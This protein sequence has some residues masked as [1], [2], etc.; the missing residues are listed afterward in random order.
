MIGLADANS[1]MSSLGFQQ[2][3][4]P[5]ADLAHRKRMC[6]P[7]TTQLPHTKKQ[8]TDEN[9]AGGAPPDVSE[10]EWRARVDPCQQR[11]GINSMSN[12]PGWF[13]YEHVWRDESMEINSSVQSLYLDHN[14][15]F[16][17]ESATRLA[18]KGDAVVSHQGGIY[19]A[20]RAVREPEMRL[21]KP[22][23]DFIQRHSE[24]LDRNV[25]DVA[26]VLTQGWRRPDMMAGR[27]FR[28]VHGGYPIR[29]MEIIRR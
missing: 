28:P 16:S 3:I 9:R 2:H 6:E 13:T 25:D 20:L 17:V 11:D 19:S 15:V 14:P 4:L 7:S 21:L 18:M 24:L 23:M 5:T 1:P 22:Q 8:S 29:W 26:H 10:A 12:H 27:L